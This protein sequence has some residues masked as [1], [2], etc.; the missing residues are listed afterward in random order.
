MPAEQQIREIPVYIFTGFLEAGKTKFIRE[1][2]EDKRFNTGERTLLICCEEGEEEYGLS[3]MKNASQIRLRTVEDEEALTGAVLAQWAAETQPERVMVEY[4]GMWML[5]TLYAALPQSWVVYQEFCFAD[6]RSFLSY[7]ANM[8]QLVYDKL[9]GCDLVVFNRFDRKADPM[10][11]HKV[12]RGANRSCDIIY[13]DERGKS[14]YDDIEDPLPF[15]KEAKVIEIADRDYAI[16]YRDLNEELKSYDG[17]TVRFKAQVATSKELDAGTIVVGRQMMNCCAA[18][19]AFA[20]LIAIGNPR[21]DIGNGDWVDLT[22][23]IEVRRHPGYHR[24]GPVLTVKEISP[25]EPPEEEVAT[26]Y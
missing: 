25:A 15:D 23:S 22:A 2:L 11:W 6:G 14:R 17:K 7:N 13:E 19:T 26:F 5:D 16:W 4:N 8:R 3:K 1:T 24:T 9:R 18:D 21:G 12:V 10:P 20:G